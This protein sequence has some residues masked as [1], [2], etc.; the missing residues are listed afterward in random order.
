M[1]RIQNVTSFLLTVENGVPLGEVFSVPFFLIAIND[2]SKSV[3]FPLTLCLFADDYGISLRSSNPA[4][5]HRPLQGV[6]SIIT[7]WSNNKGFRFFSRKT[8]MVIFKKRSPIPCLEP[9][10]LQ[11]FQIPLRNSA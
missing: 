4:R 8:Y 2:T 1:V 9:M 10:F 7:L 3:K 5:A 6:L 11:D